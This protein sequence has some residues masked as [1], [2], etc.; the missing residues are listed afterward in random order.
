[1]HLGAEVYATAGS[2]EKR[3][4]VALLGAD[5]VLDSRS[6]AFADQILA[7][8]DGEGVDVVLNSLAGEALRRGLDVLRP[9]GRFLEIGKRDFFENTPIGLRPFKNNISYFG[10]D[11]DQLL[12]ARPALAGR[13]FREV[14]ALFRE[15]VLFPLPYRLFPA[16]NVVDAFRT[17]QQAQQIG[18]VIVGIEGATVAVESAPAHV[19]PLRFERRSSWLVTGG[20]AGFGLESA[21]WLAERGVGHLVLVGRRGMRTPGAAEAVRTLEA[22]GARVD[23]IACDI[24]DRSAVQSMVSEIRSSRPPLT[25]VLHAAMVLDDALIGNL[26][27]TRLRHVLAPK[28]LGAWH[29]HELT[30]EIPIEHF[31]LYSSITT[32]IGNPGQANYVAANASLESLALLRR[33]VGLPV[34]CIGW[35]PI[36]DAGF[37]TRNQAVKDA[38]AG[39]LGATLLSARAALAMLDR[40]LP[41]SAGTIAVSNFDWPTLARFLPSAKSARFE[42]LRRRAGPTAEAGAVNDDIRVM[43]A[44]KTRE[45]ALRIAQELVVQEVAQVLCVAPD[46]VD[47]R[48]SVHDLGMDSLMA[49]ELVMGL[50]KR[51]GLELP[52]MML[53]EGTTVERVAARVIDRLLRSD[54]PVKAEA[55]DRFDA[56][57]ATLATQHGESLAAEDLVETLEHARSLEPGKVRLIG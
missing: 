54:D 27:A 23:V 34:T 51:F 22:I 26:D 15:K 13:L 29:L 49:V 3:D 16:A 32:M 36:S 10:I 41:R 48:R 45:E 38:L 47:P 46:R 2:D 7:M 14:M 11:A 56:V 8:T 9:F 35:G 42:W 55:G 19:S 39:R 17:M 30:L 44:G 52:A 18:K 20:I 57:A 28:L 33:A 37:L 31:V 53:S 43:I 50:E 40:L 12:I 24:S 25:G 6:L 21:R 5:H 1:M 4:F